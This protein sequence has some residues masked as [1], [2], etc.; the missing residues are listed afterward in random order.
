M[1][2]GHKRDVCRP[3]TEHITE[4]RMLH[5]ADEDNTPSVSCGTEL[6][7]FRAN[8]QRF[9]WR[10]NC[11]KC[12]RR[13][14]LIRN[15]NILFGYLGFRSP[16]NISFEFLASSIFHNAVLP[17]SPPPIICS[18]SSRPFQFNWLLIGAETSPKNLQGRRR[19]ST[20]LFCIHIGHLRSIG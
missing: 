2:K 3:N 20:M 1:S 9:V 6:L 15:L 14:I 17:P 18:S 7:A 10:E 16:I 11:A 19:P 5:Q 4:N 8:K 12:R 13:L